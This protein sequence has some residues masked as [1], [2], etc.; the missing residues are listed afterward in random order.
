MPSIYFF[1]SFYKL[2]E[3][4]PMLYIIINDRKNI[5]YNEQYKYIHKNQQT[6]ITGYD[7]YNTLIHIIYGEKYYSLKTKNMIK[8]LQR[9]T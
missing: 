9:L 1:Y 3:H 2:E 4:L 6:L 7:I 8:I 5:T